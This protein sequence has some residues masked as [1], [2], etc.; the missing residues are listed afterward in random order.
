M[1]ALGQREDFPRRVSG[2]CAKHMGEQIGG[3]RAEIGMEINAM[4]STDVDDHE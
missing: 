1:D 2:A 3:D 4:G